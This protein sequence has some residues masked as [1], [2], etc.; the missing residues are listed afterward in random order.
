MRSR[1]GVKALDEIAECVSGI[2]CSAADPDPAGFSG[3]SDHCGA[4]HFLT[5]RIFTQFAEGV[6]RLRWPHTDCLICINWTEK[7]IF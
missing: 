7:M 5:R 2:K 6:L 3:L 4:V 1:H